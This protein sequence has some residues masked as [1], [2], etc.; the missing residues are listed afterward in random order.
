MR[1]MMVCGDHARHRF[2]LN[3][4]AERFDLCG[5][6]IQKRE[7]IV[8]IPTDELTPQDRSNFIRHFGERE[9]T[10]RQIFGNPSWCVD[11]KLEM[12]FQCLD[13]SEALQFVRNLK[14]DAALVF[15]TGLLGPELL[16]KLPP[17]TLNLHLGLS[18]RYRGAATLFWPFYFLEPAWAGAT[19]HYLVSEPD[20]GDVVHQVCPPLHRSDGIHDVGCRTVVVAAEEAV[21][22]F[23]RLEQTEKWERKRQKGT[24]KNFLVRDF[25]AQHLRVVYDLYENKLVQAFLD[26]ELPDR[27]PVLFR[28]PGCG[29]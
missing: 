9:V 10:E 22:L 26:G 3:K 23:E 28:Q 13:Q 2:V 14:P 6:L 20:A 8:P 17:H 7:P 11:Q 25:H 12:D 16:A 27:R 18:P 29:K 1:I 21:L 4:L 15:G 19:F 24:G 5:V